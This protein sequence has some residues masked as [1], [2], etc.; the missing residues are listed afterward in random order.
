MKGKG[1]GD[2]GGAEWVVV[3]TGVRARFRWVTNISPV[4]AELECA[5][6]GQAPDGEMLLDTMLC[7]AADVPLG[8]ALIC[9]HVDAAEQRASG[10]THV[11][12]AGAR[13]CCPMVPVLDG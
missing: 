11:V 5:V 1:C 10:G 12:R 2:G 3:T 13:R 9:T 7:A 8:I 6:L 4:V